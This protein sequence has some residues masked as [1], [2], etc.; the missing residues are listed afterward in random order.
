MCPTSPCS[1]LSSF[2]VIGHSGTARHFC[3]H[4]MPG[5]SKLHV[6]SHTAA[7]LTWELGTLHAW[8]LSHGLCLTFGNLC[9]LAHFSDRLSL[10][11]PCPWG[12]IWP[13]PGNKLENWAIIEWMRSMWAVFLSSVGQKPSES[14]PKLVWNI[15]VIAAVFHFALWLYHH[16]ED[17]KVLVLNS[18]LKKKRAFT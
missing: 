13:H 1:S 9:N 11:L 12:E 16:S 7:P 2:P 5:Q 4:I 8:I 18:Q 14:F 6:T 3:G 15:D 17:K 10:Y